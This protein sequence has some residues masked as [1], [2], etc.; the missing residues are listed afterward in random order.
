MVGKFLDKFSEND[1]QLTRIEKKLDNVLGSQS[2]LNT[3]DRL[4]GTKEE[5]TSQ[6]ISIPKL[7]N[8]LS[9]PNYFGSP[10]GKSIFKDF[11][12]SSVSDEKEVI[13]YKLPSSK[14]ALIRKISI[15]YSEL[16]FGTLK[17]LLDVEGT[18]LL[19]EN[20]VI[21][22]TH[23]IEKMDLLTASQTIIVKVAELDIPQSYSVVLNII[24]FSE[25]E[26]GRINKRFDL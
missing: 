25:E 1:E 17:I 15:P 10:I 9:H 19:G 3:I 2:G 11:R 6:K 8:V 7:F 5:G 22:Q 20:G 12:G 4:F 16:D 21:E 18:N 24:E 14:V 13:T 26:F 23:W